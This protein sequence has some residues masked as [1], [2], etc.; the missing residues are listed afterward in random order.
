MAA[1]TEAAD[2]SLEFTNIIAFY[3]YHYQRIMTYE[4]SKAVRES[5]QQTFGTIVRKGKK[6][7]VAHMAELFPVWFCSFFDS[8]QE[9]A[10]M[11]RSIFN[12]AFGAQKDKFFKLS[13][14]FFLNFA[15]KNLM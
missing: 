3:L 12:E 2:V 15:C 1:D 11:G 14:K 6:R 10:R 8:S 4:S 5:A 13:Y 7:I 9:V